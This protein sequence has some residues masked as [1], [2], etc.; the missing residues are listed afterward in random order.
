MANSDKVQSAFPLIRMLRAA[1]SLTFEVE[2]NN[3]FF[4]AIRGNR[5]IE[6]DRLIDA[7]VMVSSLNTAIQPVLANF[8][9]VYE[10]RIGNLIA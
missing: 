3:G 2:Q 10:Q 1:S 6:T 7:T 9:S 5:V 8:V 4:V